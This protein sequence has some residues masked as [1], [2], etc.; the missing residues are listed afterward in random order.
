M[1]TLSVNAVA[2][3]TKI[4]FWK[5]ITAIY[6]LLLSTQLLLLILQRYYFESE[7]Q[8][9]TFIVLSHTGCCLSYKDTILKANHSILGIF[10]E[11]LPAVA[12]PTKILF[13][14]RITAHDEGYVY[15]YMLLLILQRYYFES[16]S[17]RK[18]MKLTGMERCCLSYKDTILKANHSHNIPIIFNTGLLLILQRYYFFKWIIT[19]SGFSWYFASTII[20]PTL[21]AY[22]YLILNIIP[23]LY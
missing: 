21:Q 7:S 12:Y 5:R 1:G 20:Y 8:P 11:F 23:S 17:Q 4:L 6:C 19:I 22:P 15:A 13:W 9:H 18:S 3:P 16:E 2:Y 10:H 14:K